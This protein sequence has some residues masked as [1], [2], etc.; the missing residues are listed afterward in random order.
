MYATQIKPGSSVS[1]KRLTTRT[2][3]KITKEA[4]L[5]ELKR[6]TVELGELQEYLWAAGTH[7]LLVV[8]QGMDT[9]GKDGAI[10]E[11]FREVNP[12]GVIETPFKVPSAIELAHDFLWRI[13]Q[14]TPELGEIAIFNR[15]HYE[16]V[17]VVR[18]HDLVPKEIWSARYDQINEFERILTDNKTIICKFFLHVSKEKQEERLIEREADLTDAWK[19]SVS[20]WTE[21]AYWD[22]YQSAYGDAVGRCSTKFA[23]WYV[24]PA[25]QKWFRNLAVTEVLVRTLRPYLKEW[26]AK[27]EREAA[28]QLAALERARA[29]GTIPRPAL[30]GDESG[31]AAEDKD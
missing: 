4:G 9:S 30:P 29:E 17:V 28:A 12:A 2:T 19:L 26:R 24:V 25:D 7:A 6:L 10:R 14:R 13:H 22:E 20:D 21:R 18:V 1:L 8:F 3:R 5:E 15:S 31:K 23:P 16:D 11:A 27:L